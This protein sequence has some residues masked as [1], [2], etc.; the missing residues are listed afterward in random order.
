MPKQFLKLLNDRSLLQNT[1]VRAMD[2]SHAS[3]GEVVTVTLGTLK[4]E[5]IGQLN[6]VDPDL[7][8]HVLGEPVAKNTAAAVAY[9]AQYIWNTFGSDTMMWILPADH[10]IAD[11]ATLKAA[12]QSAVVAAKEDY[13]VTFGINP[14]RAETGYGY[15]K[16]AAPLNENVRGVEQFVEKP[17]MPT[18]QAYLESG[19]YLWN[20]GMFLF[21]TESVLENFRWHSSEILEGVQAALKGNPAASRNISFE[22]YSKLP[23]APFDK[24]IMEKSTRIAV[25][26]CDPQWSDIGSWVSLWELKDKDAGGNSVS[27]RVRL[28]ETKNCLIEAQDRLVAC[29]GLEDIVVVETA[30]SV[31]ISSKAQTDNIKVLLS[32]LRKVNA[33]EVTES[34]T[35]TRPWG[36]FKIVSRSKNYKIK[37]TVILAGQ[38]QSLQLHN[39]RAEFWTVIDGEATIT[40]DNVDY[41]VT[42][43]ET[44][45]ASSAAFN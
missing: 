32:D 12:L 16:L 29:A 14:N 23:S 17:D 1:A 22:H 18:A 6:E 24:A 7:T 35:E 42:A 40:V 45:S 31:L 13:L 39:H 36:S 28:H 30:D 44:I 27:G 3:S 41:T 21:K 37:E 9:A 15:I 11:E 33:P 4:K 26:P 34:T 38:M 5:V 8:Q 10:H 2:L 19:D 43:G 20:S 25:V